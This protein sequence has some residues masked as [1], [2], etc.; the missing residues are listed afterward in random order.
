VE[1]VS[2]V[3]GQ[4]THHIRVLERHH[5]N[6]AVLIRSD[7]D[8]LDAGL[9]ETADCVFLLLVLPLLQLLLLFESSNDAGQTTDQDKQY[10]Y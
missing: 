6:C 8:L 1:V 2:N 9:Q 5:A 4:R 10:E 3:A 7:A